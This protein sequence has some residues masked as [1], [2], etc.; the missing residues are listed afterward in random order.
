M[1]LMRC[2]ALLLGIGLLAGCGNSSP[3]G[4]K[5]AAVKGKVTLDGE[6]MPEGKITFDGRD[7]NPP[8]DLEVKN[9]TFS[10]K[11]G[12]GS[13]IVRI[14]SY[15]KVVQTA[16]GPGG[17]EESLVNILPPQHNTESTRTVEVTESGPNEFDFPVTTK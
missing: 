9:G 17:N 5:L 4:P 15:K 6:P 10:G 16:S 8:V 13:P 14:S 12:V 1:P 2:V 7:G 3:P 11:V